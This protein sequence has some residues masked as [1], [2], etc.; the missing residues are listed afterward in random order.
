[1]MYRRSPRTILTLL[2]LISSF[3]GLKA[4]TTF[5]LQKPFTDWTQQEYM[6]GDWGGNRKKLVEQY[7]INLEAFYFSALPTNLAGGLNTGTVYEGL[8]WASLDISTEKLLGLHGGHLYASMVWIHGNRFSQNYSGDANLASL[9]DLPH[10]FRL[11]ELFYEQKF[12]DDKLSIKLGQL[13]V[14]HDFIVPELYSNLSNITLLNQTF[15]YPTVA[16]GIFDR[17]FYPVENHG[18]P[19]TP[20]AAPGIRFRLDVTPQFY[21]QTG[22]YGGAPDTT[23]HGVNFNLSGDEGVLAYFETGYKMN[24][25]PDT[26][27]L[28]ASFK[29]GGYYHRDDFVDNDAILSVF[30]LP[31]SG[32]VHGGN[33]G[34][35]FLAE[36]TLFLENGKKDPANQGLVGYA[37]A[38]YAPA[39][40]NFFDWGADGGLV[41][42]GLIPSRDYDTT[43]MAFSYLSVSG[44]ICDAQN[45]INRTFPGSFPNADFEAVFELS[46]KAQVTPWMTMHTSLQR[47]FHPGARIAAKT[48][49]AWVFIA[50]SSLRF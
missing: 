9:I 12:W 45:K 23:Y 19:S 11:L 15:Y 50:Q 30:G 41:Y 34:F 13:S 1:M 39:D 7:G 36:Q 25:G 48:P 33:Y 14:D 18:L 42:K 38:A 35:Y 22:L 44:D 2:F 20:Y 32:D 46:Y 26:E 31:A 28:P 8:L 29:L 6:F 5:P 17:A 10:S 37:R 43:A 16:F 49:D 24:F 3:A 47:I 21:L 40:R 27:G 4:E